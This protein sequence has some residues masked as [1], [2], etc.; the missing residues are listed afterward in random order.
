MV[1][2]STQKEVEYSASGNVSCPNGIFCAMHVAYECSNTHLL[3]QVCTC[4]KAQMDIVR[5]GGES[6]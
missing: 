6:H 4:T 5:N 1:K 2:I 3:N